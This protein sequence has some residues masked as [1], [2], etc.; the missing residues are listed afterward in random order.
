MKYLTNGFLKKKNMDKIKSKKNNI[1]I[2]NINGEK[3]EN[4]YY[5][6]SRIYRL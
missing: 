6:R 1:D 5:R 4:A 2:E 3:N